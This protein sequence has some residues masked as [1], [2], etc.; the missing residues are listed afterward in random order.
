METSKEGSD[1]RRSLLPVK[2]GFQFKQLRLYLLD[3][4]QELFLGKLFV[5]CLFSIDTLEN[6]RS[7]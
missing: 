7:Q 2:V 4:F 5:C 6:S 3:Y 1:W